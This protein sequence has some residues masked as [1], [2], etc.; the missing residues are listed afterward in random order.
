[1]KITDCTTLDWLLAHNSAL[2]TAEELYNA[3]W[4]GPLSQADAGFAERYEKLA[5]AINSITG[6]FPRLE[7][8]GDTATKDEAGRGL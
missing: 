6:L 1:M 5:K 3:S 8:A 2:V 4:E 7:Y